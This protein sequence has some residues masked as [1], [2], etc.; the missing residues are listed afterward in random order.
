VSMCFNENISLSVVAN[1]LQS[2]PMSVVAN[3]W[4]HGTGGACATGCGGVSVT[5]RQSRVA[6]PPHPPFGGW[7]PVVPQGTSPLGGT[8]AIYSEMEMKSDISD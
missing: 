2:E 4:Q 7:G 3:C 8:S 1:G 5:W 6:G